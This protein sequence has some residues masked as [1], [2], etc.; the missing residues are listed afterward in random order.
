MQS[1]MSSLPLSHGLFT[2]NW[3]CLHVEPLTVQ[4]VHTV[5]KSPSGQ[6]GEGLGSDLT[7]G[8]GKANLD[9]LR[10]LYL[11]DESRV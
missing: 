8:S 2:V 9:V 11:D 3:I 7:V 1:V 4:K 6:S 10:S 5:L